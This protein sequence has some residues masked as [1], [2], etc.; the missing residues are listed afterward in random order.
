ML[1]GTTNLENSLGVFSPDTQALHCIQILS[2]VQLFVTVWTIPC[3]APLS[4]RILQARILKRIAV[5]STRGSSQQGDQILI[6]YVSCT[7]GGFFTTSTTREATLL[8]GIY[9]QKHVNA[10]AKKSHVRMIL[11]ELYVIATN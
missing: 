7:A 3:Q 5:P 4:M 9:Q 11:A 2:C 8:L 10:Y 6:S 1:T